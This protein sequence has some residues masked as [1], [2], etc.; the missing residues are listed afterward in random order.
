MK[1]HI[2]A[3]AALALTAASLALT[4]CATDPRLGP[5]SR[6]GYVSE[7]YTADKLR[8]SPPRCLASLTSAQ[9]A[10]GTY[11]GIKVPHGR[12][13]EYLSAH[14]PASIKPELHDKVEISPPSCKDGNVPEVIQILSGSVPPDTAPKTPLPRDRK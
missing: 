3:L 5:N 4:G 12:H 8:V 14:V 11:V 13:S 9:I 7:I 6:A 1:T 10:A 2:F